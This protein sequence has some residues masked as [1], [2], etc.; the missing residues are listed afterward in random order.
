MSP[1]Q[2][3]SEAI[4]VLG[5]FEKRGVLKANQ[6]DFFR[7]FTTTKKRTKRE[8]ENHDTMAPLN[9]LVRPRV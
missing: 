7:C 6:A 5:I 3:F 4:R 1:S 2:G 8:R 9:T